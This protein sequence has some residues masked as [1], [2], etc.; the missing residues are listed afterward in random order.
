[1]ITEYIRYQLTEHAPEAFTDAYA[2]A[3]Q[4]LQVAPECLGYELSQCA[5]E[6]NAFVLRILWTSTQAHM[7]GFRRGHNFPPF[8]ALIRPF[9]QEIEEMRHYA[10]TSV[11][12]AR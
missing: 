3:G 5:E 6:P 8:L 2:R 11:T 7:E 1:M 4:H 9:I 10:N 12:W